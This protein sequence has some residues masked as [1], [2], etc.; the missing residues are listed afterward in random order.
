MLKHEDSMNLFA[1]ELQKIKTQESEV[2]KEIDALEQQ[3]FIEQQNL[4][5]QMQFI[6][7]L[8]KIN[9][10]IHSG[11]IQSTSKHKDIKSNHGLI[12]NHEKEIKNIKHK[13]SLIEKAI[14]KKHLKLLPFERQINQINDNML[15]EQEILKKHQQKESNFYEVNQHNNQKIYDTMLKDFIAFTN[16]HVAFIKTLEDT[17]YV[18]DS[19]L[20]QEEKKLS[21]V[22][23]V[24][25]QKLIKNQQSLLKHIYSF[26]HDNDQKQTDIV[27]DFDKSQEH[28][29][30]ELK[31]NN[32]YVLSQIERFAKKNIIDKDNDIKNQEDLYKST[33]D[34]KVADLDKTLNNVQHN[35]KTLEFRLQEHLSFMKQELKSINDNQTQ[36][37]NQSYQ[38]YQK[39]QELLK[40]NYQKHLL[41]YQQTL[42]Q[43]ERTYQNFLQSTDNKNQTLLS[44]F[45]QNRLK[46][47]E[48]HKQK[49]E[50]FD[51]DLE[52]SRAIQ[53]KREKTYEQD[54]S[55]MQENRAH[56]IRNMNEHIKKYNHK[57]EKAQHK[58]MHQEA[59]SLR[60]N[61]RFKIKE[62]HLK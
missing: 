21:R 34:A 52:K 27:T 18:T 17:A 53:E 7:Q 35:I 61:F 36:I 23:Y 4:E 62:L 49:N 57:S 14:D 25:E 55:S 8:E 43:E 47:L 3:F 50:H 46:Q 10:N 22:Q 13:L 59:K 28:W 40:S 45:E 30:N 60:K 39:Q 37:A 20:N 58:I 44:R 56:E 42:E 54:V 1:Q 32:Q 19:Q 33:K 6:T 15:R 41:K 11:I 26:Y 9:V 48:N 31:K 29:V 51:Q 24:F 5:R 2:K 38:E 16:Q 12:Q